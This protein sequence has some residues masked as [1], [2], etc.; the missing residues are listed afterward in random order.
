MNPVHRS[1]AR[2]LRGLP[3]LGLGWVLCLLWVLRPGTEAFSEPAGGTVPLLVIQS[4]INPAISDY[5]EKGLEKA[6]REGAPC[7]ILEMDTPGGL[8]TAMRD[9]V[10][11]ILNSPVPVVVYIA[12]SGAR[13]ASAG[14]LITMAAHVAAMAPGTNIGAA[15][16]V[17]L[18]GEKMDETML[19]KVENDAAA[20]AKSLAEQRGRN[21]DWAVKA[22]RESESVSATKA[23][24]L[25]VIDL[26]AKDRAELLEKIN[27]REV[28]TVRGKKTI[29]VKDLAVEP[30]EMSWRYR[31][32][33]ALSNPNIAYLLMML[34]FY[35]LFFELSSP[36]VI[37]PGVFGAIC[38][39]LAFFALQTLPV[40]Y[41]G[42]LLILL[43][44]ILFIAE[45]KV[46]S[47]GVL[48]LGGVIAMILG[49]LMLFDSPEPYLRVS[50][51]V[52]FP[53]VLTTVGFFVFA[54]SFALKAQLKKPTTGREGLLGMRGK[55]LSALNPH[56]RVFVHG[57]YWS[58][59]SE[60]AIETGSTIEV[61]GVHE[62]TLKVKE[63]KK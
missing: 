61:T 24:E 22:V 30:I 52:I 6:A 9:I 46:T 29:Q 33:D 53:L 58:A 28:Q 63:V 7:V 39:I 4:T 40:N 15:H 23:L 8:D 34:G 10:Q 18:G 27:G 16:P 14:V 37:F 43:A 13:A 17:G 36:G 56:G 26:M 48:T 2:C 51:Y 50:W 62:L 35:G 20:Y 41:A 5:V 38:L 44:I 19:K 49:S 11:S 45:I 42:V 54:L 12:P 32:L 60:E 1:S 55:A 25:R 21:V 47:Y 57:E 59:E 3:V 31:L